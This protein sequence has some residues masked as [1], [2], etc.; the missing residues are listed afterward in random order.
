MAIYNVIRSLPVGVVAGVATIRSGE[1]AKRLS[2]EIPHH[3]L[4][5]YQSMFP[6]GRGSPA[7]KMGAY[8]VRT[9]ER[10]FARI[11]REIP[12]DVWVVNTL[13]WPGAV[14]YAERHNIP[15][16]VQVCELEHMLVGLT[17]AQLEQ[18][19]RA[20]RLILAL[21]LSVAAMLR[22]AGRHDRMEI[23]PPAL[24]TA[25][26]V[27]RTPRAEMRRRLGIAPDAFVWAMA[28]TLTPNKNPS[29]FVDL[30]E[31]V[32]A[33]RPN[34]HFL[35]IKGGNGTDAYEFYCREKT[36]ARGLADRIVWTE[37]VRDDYY[38]H[39]AVSDAFVL[40]ST[41]E[42]FS[43]VLAEALWLGRPVVTFDCGGVVDLVP[44]CGGIIVRPFDAD[45]LVTAMVRV[46][47]GDFAFDA[48]GTRRAIER[49]DRIPVTRR[50]EELIGGYF[51][52]QTVAAG[53]SSPQ[54]SMA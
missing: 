32:I 35:W 41:Q 49:C 43:L 53:V 29:L 44:P 11:H 6:G 18:L 4:E 40:P 28:G 15:L 30:A 47:D 38:D 1:L 14:A 54:A 42:S 50:W 34:C 7:N 19:V 39:F 33:A 12:A 8:L 2:A 5:A 31:R 48:E 26:V 21:S 17:P 9:E 46:V 52:R 10:F 20:P 13:A 27:A 16:V 36:R 24:D 23:C 45:A 22:A 3:N 37:T 25:A 51:G